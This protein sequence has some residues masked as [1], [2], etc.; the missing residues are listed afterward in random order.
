MYGVIS[1]TF[2][3]RLVSLIG[4]VA[5]MRYMAIMVHACYGGG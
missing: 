5:Y 2:C 4:V 3:P 1:G